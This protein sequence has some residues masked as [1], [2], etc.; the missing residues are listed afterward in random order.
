MRMLSQGIFWK[1]VRDSR[2]ERSGHAKVSKIRCFYRAISSISVG[3]YR[4]DFLHL[5]RNLNNCNSISP[6]GI[7]I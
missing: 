2:L 4:A 1:V 5:S 7:L 3:E 6:Y